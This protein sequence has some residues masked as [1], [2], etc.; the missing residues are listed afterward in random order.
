MKYMILHGYLDYDY[1]H[2]ISHFYPNSLK[3]ADRNFVMKAG[4]SEGVFFDTPLINV[5]EVL[6]R[7]DKSEFESNKSLLNVF[8]VE[9]IFTQN[10]Y[11][12]FRSA[13]IKCIYDYQC[14]DF[15]V[16]CCR[17]K[18]RNLK[19]FFTALLKEYDFWDEIDN[20]KVIDQDELRL[21]YLN[22]CLLDDNHVNSGFKSW[23]DTHYSFLEKYW[24]RIPE[25][26]AIRLFGVYKPLFVKLSLKNTPD[27]VFNDIV[28][29]QWYT[30]GR[31]NFSAII[32]RFGFWKSYDDAP[33]SAIIE[34]KNQ[35]LIR[36]MKQNW[37]KM[38]LD[39]FPSSHKMKEKEFAQ[40]LL[41]NSSNMPDGVLKPYLS[42]QINKIIHADM[43]EE[44]A[45]SFAYECFFV[46]PS[47]KN[48]SYY[49]QI[50]R[51]IPIAFLNNCTIT[52]PVSATLSLDEESVLRKM[53]VFS[54]D[55]DFPAYK[56]IVPCFSLPFSAVEERI[57]QS[58]LKFLIDNSYLVLNKGTFDYT[59]G[60]GF[61]VSLILNNLTS[62]LN[63]PEPYPVS[64]EMVKSV[65][66][67]I[68][69]KKGQCDYLR[70]I[71]DKSVV[72]DP[73]IEKTI[74]PLLLGQ[75]LKPSDINED[76]LIS[77]I[78]STNNK[79][80]KIVIGRRALLSQDKANATTIFILKAMGSPYSKFVTSSK[81]SLVPYDNST[82]RVAN[83][84]KKKDILSEVIRDAD[85]LTVTKNHAFIDSLK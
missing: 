66:G 67:R 20:C 46:E 21:V 29:N 42:R 53:I 32:R 6:K 76:L 18:D 85:V 17:A 48:I 71:K 1:Q 70:S 83:D 12:V 2:Y 41:L 19:S 82:I 72:A 49:V 14:T 26:R 68:V 22:H 73:S 47:W 54:N 62:Y 44:S 15:I 34:F 35:A 24:D 5:D 65:L 60:S 36:T 33:I 4:R 57:S 30:L 45:L 28:D 61:G 3:R 56:R 52:E 81:T 43:I 50:K 63:N 59:I 25:D 69:S 8:L 77:I 7:F 11:N 23:L 55:L 39:I 38:L 80:D 10:R 84:L 64:T 79:D 37:K 74:L 9:H 16:V 31:G 51:R 58:R 40:V 27:I 13:V 78:K 75:D